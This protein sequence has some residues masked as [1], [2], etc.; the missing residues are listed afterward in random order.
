MPGIWELAELA[1]PSAPQS[2]TNHSSRAGV[3]RGGHCIFAR[4]PDSPFRRFWDSGSWA[5]VR[6]RARPRCCSRRRCWRRSWS[7]CR[8]RC[9][10]N[11]RCGC[12]RGRRCGRWRRSRSARCENSHV[13]HVFFVLLSIGVEVEGGRVC[14]VPSCF[15]RND[16]DV[17]AYLVLVRIPLRGI[18]RVTYRHVRRPG[19]T[20]VSAIGIEK[21]RVCGVDSV[22][23]VVPD[24]VEPTVGRDRKCA[25]PVPLARVNRVVINLV[26]RT[27]G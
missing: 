23:R 10:S 4:F 22:S 15:I 24:R 26:R 6:S 11:R 3:R 9:W 25:K 16:G 8:C 12:R 20:S 1:P 27:E 2:F 21:L 5:R 7:S 17:I 13:V 18:E 19:D 14:H